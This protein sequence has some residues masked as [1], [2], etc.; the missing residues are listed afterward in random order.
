MLD[1][2]NIELGAKLLL[3]LNAA[4][5]SEILLPVLSGPQVVKQ[6]DGPMSF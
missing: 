3:A 4:R 2:R 6:Y 5:G 1:G